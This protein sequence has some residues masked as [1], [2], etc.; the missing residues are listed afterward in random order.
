M[1]KKIIRKVMPNPLEVILK[2]ASKN[3]TKSCLIVW[4]R[5]LG[6]IALGMYALVLRIKQVLPEIAIT[7]LTRQDLAQGFTLLEGVD[8][9]TSDAMQRGKPF[10]LSSVLTTLG[11]NQQ[12]YDLIIERPDPTYWLKW[13][14]GTVVP[15]LIWKDNWDGL[16]QRFSLA[17]DVKYLAVHIQT[18]TSYGYEKNWPMENFVNLF[19]KLVREKNRKIILFGHT[20]TE[21]IPLEDVIDLRGKT[22]L[23]EMLSIIKNRCDCLLVPDSGVLSLTYFL[24]QSFPLKVISLWADPCQGVLKQNVSS[25]NKQL[26]HFP[27]R[28]KDGDL[29]NISVESVF[30]LVNDNSKG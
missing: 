4:N 15:K 21:E 18:Q 12:S 8:V 7:F 2:K 11:K 5:G 14:L 13:Q 20:A 29:R 1:L 27:L 3:Q 16:C 24:D 10:N 17:Q 30:Y 22:S 9:I 25:P 23:I 19:C 6:D 28:A 26:D